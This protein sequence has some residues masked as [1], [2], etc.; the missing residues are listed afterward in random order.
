MRNHYKEYPVN[1]GV[2][3]GSILGPT[4]LLLYIDY[5]PDDVICNIAIYDDDIFSTLNVI[6]L[7]IC[8]N[9]QNWLLSLN[10]TYETLWTRAGSGVKMDGFVLERK[11]SFK[12]LGLTFSSKLDWVK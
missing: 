11:T 4:Y 1:V 6:R 7:L 5:L 9:K 3:Q 10:L 2:P 12:M 8:G